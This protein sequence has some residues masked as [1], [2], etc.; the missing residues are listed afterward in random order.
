MAAAATAIAIAS[1]APWPD[2]MW[3]YTQGVALYRGETP[4]TMTT[5]RLFG[6]AFPMLT[7]EYQG[8]F[9]S[10]LHAAF[11]LATGGAASWQRWLNFGLF[12]AVALA[13]A[14]AI[15]PVARGWL[16]AVP[17]LAAVC[18][19]NYVAFVPSDMGPFLLQNLFTALAIGFM[20]R[21]AFGGETRHM[22]AALAFCGA[23]AGDKLTGIPV[24]AGIGAAC[25]SSR[26][27]IARC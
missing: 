16:A 10:Y 14:W 23:I 26:C 21:G 20:L 5:L 15:R 18:D 22:I 2:E 6:H 1:Y 27:V 12:A 17:A 24:A 13:M 25:L 3:G 4:D 8:A 19:P 11:L 9:K 7:G